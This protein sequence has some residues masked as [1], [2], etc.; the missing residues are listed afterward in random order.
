MLGLLV[1]VLVGCG[2]S[3]VSVAS[4]PTCS[5]SMTPVELQACIGEEAASSEATSTAEDPEAREEAAVEAAAGPLSYVGTIT[6]SD[7]EGTSFG[8]RFKVSRLH[9]SSDLTPPEAA[10]AACDDN[11]PAGIASSVF[12]RGEATISYEE[13]SLPYEFDVFASGLGSLITFKVGGAWECSGTGGVV[14]FQPGETLS[15]PFWIVASQMISNAKP[16]IDWRE[17]DS[18]AVSGANGGVGVGSGLGVKQM[19]GPGA[20][21]CKELSSQGI[22]GITFYQLLLY[23]RPPLALPLLANSLGG[24]TTCR[25]A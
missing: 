15:F 14:T 24:G 20:V 2:G 25:G 3:T 19:R 12:A 10:L 16:G 8:E 18:W 9:K 7:N 4:S 17:V 1:L 22:E 23:G 13:G 6:Y 21:S 11:Y 5:P